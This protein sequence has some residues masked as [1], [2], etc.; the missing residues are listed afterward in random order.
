MLGPSGYV[1][2]EV[3]AGVDVGSGTYDVRLQCYGAS[4]TFHRGNLIAT[5]RRADR[6]WLRR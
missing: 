6:I 2:V 4:L 1:P 3:S 5:L